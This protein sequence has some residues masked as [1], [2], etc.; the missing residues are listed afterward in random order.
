LRDWIW[1]QQAMEG[2]NNGGDWFV[3]D[4]QVVNPDDPDCVWRERDTTEYERDTHN[5]SRARA[6]VG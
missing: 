1:A 3:V 5:L 4:P 6:A 2:G